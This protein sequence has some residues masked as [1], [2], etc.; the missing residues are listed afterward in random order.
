L[1]TIDSRTQETYCKSI[2]GDAYSKEWCAGFYRTAGKLDYKQSP[3]PRSQLYLEGQVYFSRGLVSIPDN[4]TLL[5][6]LRLLERRVARSGRDSVNHPGGG[7]D[8]HANSL[9]GCLY[10]A[11]KATKRKPLHLHPPYA[12]SKS[13]G[14]IS[15]PAP[16]P[17]GRDATRAFYEYYGRDGYGGGS[18]WPGS[19]PREY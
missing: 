14:V 1:V 17:A 16:G 9:F 4:P 6:E 8:D 2:T 19:G 11:L 15:D 12:V 5:R 18:H 13:S 3:L 7:H 10:V